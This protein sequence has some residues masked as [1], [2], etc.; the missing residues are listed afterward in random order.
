MQP[1]GRMQWVPRTS[2]GI[3]HTCKFQVHMSLQ[4]QV[5]LL[6]ENPYWK[7]HLGPKGFVQVLPFSASQLSPASA[8]CKPDLGSLSFSV[9]RE[10]RSF[11]CGF[12]QAL[13]WSSLP[14]EVE[15]DWFLPFPALCLVSHFLSFSQPFIFIYS[16]H[17]FYPSHYCSYSICLNCHLTWAGMVFAIPHYLLQKWK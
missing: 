3:F 16:L 1:G 6:R 4:G 8:L 5:W 9:K 15:P 14:A 10:I 12:F 7:A 17:F 2:H 13:P 11:Q